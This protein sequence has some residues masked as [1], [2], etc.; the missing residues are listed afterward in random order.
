LIAAIALAGFDHGLRV[1]LSV[2]CKRSSNVGFLIE[3]TLII[4]PHEAFVFAGVYQFAFAC[5]AFCHV[6]PLNMEMVRVTLTNTMVFANDAETR[7]I[8]RQMAKRATT[9]PGDLAFRSERC[10]SFAFAILCVL[11]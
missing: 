8:P 9:M 2:L 6:I 3:A 1:F 5:L 7:K 10:R 4:A 11:A